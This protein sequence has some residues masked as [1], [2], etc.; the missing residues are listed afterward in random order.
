MMRTDMGSR[1]IDSVVAGILRDD[2]GRP[3][4]AWAIAQK[5]FRQGPSQRCVPP[6]R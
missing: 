1:I 3:N 2:G 6:P 5:C 4:D